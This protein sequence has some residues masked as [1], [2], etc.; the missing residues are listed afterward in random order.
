ML[1]DIKTRN[2]Y[3][4]LKNT[5]MH[6][7]THINTLTHVKYLLMVKDINAKNIYNV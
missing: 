2:I 6:T 5:C 3:N 1:K 7:H 4:V